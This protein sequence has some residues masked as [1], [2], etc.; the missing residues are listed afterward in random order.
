MME[1][2]DNLSNTLSIDRLSSNKEIEDYFQNVIR[3]QLTLKT[4]ELYDRFPNITF[5]CLPAF[6]PICLLVCL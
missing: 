3:P 5:R 1:M 6:I 2:F 4:L